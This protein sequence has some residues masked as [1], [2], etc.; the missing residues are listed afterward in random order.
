MQISKLIP[1]VCVAA[2]CASFIAV[3]AEDT[4]A[5]AA[6]RAALMDKMNALETQPAQPAQPAPPPIV[7]TPSGATPVKP[8]QPTKAVVIPSPAVQAQ[9][10]VPAPETKPM[11]GTEAVQTVPVTSD[12]EAQARARGALEHKMSELNKQEWTTPAVV[13]AAP[14][15][16]QTQPVAVR[17]VKPAPPA[18]NSGLTLIAAPPVPISAAKQAQLQALLEKY[19]ADQITPGEYHTERAKIL[20]EP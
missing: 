15:A 20:A 1:V 16:P 4:P 8:S 13:P 6:A 2:F 18:D 11:P 17:P 7:V 14:S 12:A 10:A 5:Q 19:K 9:P 3:R